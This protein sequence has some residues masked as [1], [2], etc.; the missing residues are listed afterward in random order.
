[1]NEN[2]LQEIKKTMFSCGYL[3]LG[4]SEIKIPREDLFTK[5][6]GL[7]S[8]IKKNKK[9]KSIS[10]AVV[11]NEIK[12][13]LKSNLNS[14]EKSIIKEV[15]AKLHK[16]Y[17]VFQTRKKKKIEK[18]LD[19][20]KNSNSKKQ[21]LE[22]INKILSSVLSTKERLNDYPKIYENIFEITGKPKT[23]VDLGAGL[24]PFSIIY[25]NLD[26]FN[27]YSYDI[28][29]EDIKILNEFFKIINQKG[30]ASLID[31]RNLREISNIPSADIIFL[32]KVIDIIDE[33]NHKFS[34]ELIKQ[35]V[36]K[37]KFIIA[38]FATK[39]ITR[40]KMNFPERKWFEF[41]LNR[42]NLK[43]KAFRTENEIFYVIGKY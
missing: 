34:E 29:E 38:S 36:K 43:F 24:N 33:K 3:F 11:E 15:R 12:N 42:N 30:K 13:Y 23:I 41:M 8:D 31:I 6:S 9:Y 25:M 37:T 5:L 35:L 27:Y 39:T 32:F 26:D 40:K 1:M 4:C 21:N 19:E 28:N 7:I 2:I 18:Y 14:S 17:S 22:I 10:D 16:N 20:L